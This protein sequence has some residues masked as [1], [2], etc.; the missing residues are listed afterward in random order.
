MGVSI[1]YFVLGTIR[2][3]QTLNIRKFH[4]TQTA[5]EITDDNYKLAAK[6]TDTDF[7]K[8]LIKSKQQNDLI[9][10]QLSN[11][12]YASFTL[13]RNG[14]ILFVFFFIMTIFVSYFS[15]QNKTKDIYPIN[16]EIQMK[17][18]DSIDVIIPYTFELKYDLQNLEI[19]KNEKK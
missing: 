12:T 3:I 10:V 11:Y 4:V 2:A 6:K 8:E 19:D 14:I 15:K 9:N 18:N 13:I 16:K 5:I 17:I 7:L 1:L